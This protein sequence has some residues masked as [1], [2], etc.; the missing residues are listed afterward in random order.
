M[1]LEDYKHKI[2]LYDEFSSVVKDIL[3]AAIL[4]S[5]QDD[6]YHYH[7]QQIQCRAKTYESLSKRLKE[8]GEQDSNQIEKIRHDLSGCRI[9]FYFNDDVNAFLYSGIIRDNFKID[10][11]RSKIH[12]PGAS[13]KVANDYYT[14]NHYVAELNEDRLKLSEY[15]KFKGLK[16][17]IQ[18]QTVL[19]HAWSET[20]HDITYKKPDDSDF[21]KYVLDAIDDRLARIMEQHLKPA[22]YEFQKIQRDHRRLLEGKKLLGRD[23]KQE[24]IDCQNNNERHEILE[25]YKKYTLPHFSD[26]Q[27][28]LPSILDL[29]N[30]AIAESN[31]IN[32][33]KIETPLGF[34]P[35][36]TSKDILIICLSIIN[37][38]RYIDPPRIFKFLVNQYRLLPDEENKKSI[39]EAVSRLIKYDINVLEKFGFSVQHNI[40]TALESLELEVLTSVKPLIAKIGCNILD[41]IIQGFSNDHGS[42]TIRTGSI[43][44]EEQV[45][46]LRGRMLKLMFTRYNANDTENIKRLFVSAFNTAT[47]TP[48]VGNYSDDLLEIILGNCM[49]VIEFYTTMISTEQYEVL[50][51]IEADICCLYRRSLKMIDGEKNINEKCKATYKLI[52]EKSITFRD[53]LNNVED[54]VIYKTLVG[55]EA[56]FVKS[57]QDLEW[58]FTEKDD[59]RKKQI[60]LYID[61][62][63]HDNQSH[64]KN[65]IIRC[66]QTKSKDLATFP[67][68]CKF[69]NLLAAAQ[70]TFSF[71]LIKNSEQ[72]LMPFSSAIFDGLLRS[73]LHDDLIAQ[74]NTWIEDGKYLRECAS[75]FAVF[76]SPLDKK[77]LSK[78]LKMAYEH[79]DNNALT[80]LIVAATKNYNKQN[81]HLIR[82]LFLPTI[83]ALTKLNDTNWITNL[84]FRDELKPILSSLNLDEIQTVLSNL[85]LLEKIDYHAEEVLRPIAEKHPQEILHFFKQRIDIGSNSNKQIK[86]YEAIPFNFHRLTQPLANHLNT[87]LATV[88]DWCNGDDHLFRIYV[89]KLISNIFPKYTSELNTSLL[90]LVSDGNEKDYRMVIAILCNYK[91]TPEINNICKDIISKLPE[92]SDLLISISNTMQNTG[93]VEGEYG[94]VKALEEKKESISS[95]LDDSNPK[96][97]KFAEKYKANLDKQIIYQQRQAEEDL[98]LRKRRN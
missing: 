50:E 2:K 22:G 10:R 17:E 29:A 98:E 36:K 44:A 1:N 21:G 79:S 85:I 87:V 14:A 60:K 19:N 73:K 20:A 45:S 58:H 43:P 71:D 4:A 7:L 67:I 64:W 95:W 26:Y 62:I 86:S 88:S 41:P 92:K 93:I 78:I 3:A 59:Y 94:L 15:L 53:Q 34:M 63:T 82:S 37:Y 66:T 24:I 76:D 28:E 13:P 39:I 80:K 74:M 91:G 40:L 89:A 8:K 57:W 5:S 11:D 47:R 72:E 75:A 70:P 49:E 83:E 97:K 42:F 33:V 61:Q 51:L 52:A 69:L 32:P 30:T 84:W 23:L 27:N 68:F 38:V 6:G 54:Y 56:P 48:T 9:I 12:G 25:H 81:K 18:I 31:K 96:V 16:C 65:I 46:I 35:G 55:F 90:K 77:L